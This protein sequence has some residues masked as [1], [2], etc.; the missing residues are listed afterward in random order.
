MPKSL[1]NLKRAAVEN[2]PTRLVSN[3]QLVA[4]LALVSGLE[5]SDLFLP[6]ALAM[7]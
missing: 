1:S 2:T 3:E 7:L 4:F 5:S 6:L